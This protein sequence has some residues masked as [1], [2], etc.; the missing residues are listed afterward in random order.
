MFCATMRAGGSL[1]ASVEEGTEVFGP[2]L[3]MGA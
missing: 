1:A 3:K 2:R